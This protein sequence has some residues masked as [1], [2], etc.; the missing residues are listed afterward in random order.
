MNWK[1]L[2]T[3]YFQDQTTGKHYY[4]K[5]PRVIYSPKTGLYNMWVFDGQAGANGAMLIMQS[6]GSLEHTLCA[7]ERPRRHARP[8]R[9]GHQHWSRW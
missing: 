2:G 3:Q 8:R 7:A 9:H 6:H 5:K 1:F 4:I